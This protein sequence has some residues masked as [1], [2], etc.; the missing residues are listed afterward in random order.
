MCS[1]ES[2]P[3][4]RGNVARIVTHYGLDALGI[5]SWGGQDYPCAYRQALRPAKHPHHWVLGLI[6]RVKWPGHVVDTIS[7]SSEAKERVES[8]TSTPLGLHGLLYVVLTVYCG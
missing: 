5:E 7:S 1:T 4:G 8:Y 2:N 3:V 6:S